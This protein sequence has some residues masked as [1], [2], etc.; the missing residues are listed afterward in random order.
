MELARQSDA[1]ILAI[2]DPIM[3]NLM[4]GSAKIDHAMHTRDFT[5]RMKSLV[6]PENLKVMC[7]S[8]Q[9]EIGLF[10][11]RE[12]LAVLRREKSV[13]VIWRHAAS[14]SDD[15]FAASVVIVEKDGKYLVD[16]A[17]IY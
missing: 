5:Q 7:E 1:E 3:D 14:K 15:E 9:A 13:C 12:L 8:Y 4:E 11:T 6:T 2:V 16:H 17:L 10:T